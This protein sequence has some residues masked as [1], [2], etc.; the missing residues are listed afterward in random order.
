MKRK[1]TFLVTFLFLLF[2]IIVPLRAQTAPGLSVPVNG[3]TWDS[4]TPTMWWWYVPT[5]YSAGP[6]TYDLEI[7][8]SGS[9]FVSPNLIYSTTVSGGGSA[10]FA[11][12]SGA[13]LSTGVTYYWRVGVGGNYSTVFSFTP[14]TGGGGGGGSTPPA[15]PTPLSPTL[16]QINVSTSPTFSWTTSAGATSY[17][18]QVSTSNSFGSFVVD[19]TG[20]TTTS[21]DASG[22]TTSTMYYWRVNA[23]NTYGTSSY[24]STYYFT[25]E[26]AATPPAAPILAS[27]ANNATNVGNHPTLYWHPAAG[28][29]TYELLVSSDNF[30][31]VDFDFTGIVDTSYHIH[32]WPSDYLELSTDYYWKVVA[33]NTHG[34]DTST[35][36]K[37]TTKSSPDAPELVSPAD[38]STDVSQL[39]TFTWTPEFAAT[40]YSLQI[41]TNSSFSS[42]VQS[43]SGIADTTFTLATPLPTNTLYYWRVNSYS[44]ATGDSSS[45]SGYFRF[46]TAVYT[47]WYVRTDGDNGNGGLSPDDAF[48]TI[49]HAINTA[50]AGDKIDV[51]AG[52][53]TQDLSIISSKSNLEIYGA[54]SSSTTIKGVDTVASTS[55]PLAS[56]NFNILASGVKVH[57]FTFE[58]PDYIAG[59]YSSGMIIGASN[60]EI[61]DNTFKVPA[62]PNTDDIS[63]ALQTYNVTAMASVDISGLDIHDNIFEDL[64]SGVWGFEAIYINRDT[65]TDLITIESND[66]NGDLIRAITD[67]RSNC[68]ILG[69]NI[70]TDLPPTDG[71]FST[72]GAYQGINI[73]PGADSD[74]IAN[75]NIK[76]NTINGS[77]S[78]YGFY[79][80]L[81]LGNSSIQLS[82][83][84]VNS[85]DI[86]NNSIG[87][88]LSADFS[89]MP[90]TP[91]PVLINSNTIAN[92][93]IGLAASAVTGG[94]SS[95]DY[96]YLDA[97]NNW[98]GSS[99]GP[100]DATYNGGT[101]NE[102]P[103]GSATAIYTWVNLV[104]ES[105]SNP[106]GNSVVDN[107]A[108]F[109]AGGFYVKYYPWNGGSPTLTVGSTTTVTGATVS[110]PV[111][112]N[113]FG[114]SFQTLQGKFTYDPSKLDY[115]SAS[116][117]TGTLINASGWVI[118]FSE[119]VPGTLNFVGV[120]FTP[121][122][123]SG[124][125]FKLNFKVIATSAG[126][127]NISVNDP[128]FLV[129]GSPSVF[130]TYSGTI[131]YSFQQFTYLR[132]DVNLDGQVTV[133][134]ALLLDQY[135]Q[136][137]ISLSQLQK[138]N[139]DAD[140]NGHL[141]ADDIS[142]I[143]YFI[144]NG[145]WPTGPISPA[146]VNV[147]FGDVVQADNNLVEFPVQLNGS[148]NVRNL[149]MIVNYDKNAISYQTFSQL[150]NM[151]GHIV[152]VAKVVDGVA[153]FTYAAPEGQSGNITPG[154]IVMRLKENGYN[155]GPITTYY[156]VNGGAYKSGP[157]YSFNEVTGVQNQPQ[158]V[159]TNFELTQ[160][161]PNP[162]NP[163][164]TIR[165]SLPKSAYVTV[166]VY[167]MLGR[168]VKTL[169]KENMGSGTYDVKWNGDNQ[170]G[171]P[172]A[173]GT[174]IY[175]ITAGEFVSVKKM[176]LLK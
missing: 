38:L 74:P 122:A 136:T 79:Q 63:Q 106:L 104:D 8:T 112:L 101:S 129:D 72:A 32:A 154:V 61:Y 135:L 120:G 172:A 66:F 4:T 149:V 33:I 28:A 175:R 20:L 174:Y 44:S 64:T 152:D 84:D 89:G 155:G 147:N 139:G 118:L 150:I 15:A 10:S 99:S 11:V 126:S 123:T 70:Y 83:I 85:N 2:S 39:P 105:S 52:T 65:G 110:I 26:T 103:A 113:A 158:E 18:L 57:D 13:G 49:Q 144:L 14:A 30:S 45:Y 102:M 5:P 80:G 98:W 9:S 170:Y 171:N 133:D 138:D 48:L 23:T 156:S 116:Y 173:S 75:V 16:S 128:D 121:I 56:P 47:T 22:L 87:I 162:F 34:S 163:T 107:T 100:S 134:D 24:S 160:N 93:S 25:T 41:A 165:F 43:H 12:P 67:E 53:F 77:T 50:S 127:A 119:N 37:F 58:N 169:I 143:L 19:Q 176:I 153:R 140:L 78:S 111:T 159:P 125:L 132:G 69:N 29:S 46:K 145:S 124:T 164:T 40:S 130:S 3:S 91:V 68:D 114:T 151:Q 51:G 96:V 54:G 21:Y 131:T 115:V 6:F 73:S 17:G 137:L 81:R 88:N 92:N 142:A 141:D 42:M 7:S 71:A 95:S 90:P 27:P 62:S 60:V 148:S 168:E 157:S 146:V 59:A 166:K 97:T 167:D 35:T 109:T 55:W 76:N 82:G 108:D 86:E 1:Y 161:F 117:G 94:G 31:S 36:W